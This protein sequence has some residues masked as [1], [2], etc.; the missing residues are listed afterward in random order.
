MK[1]HF[2]KCCLLFKQRFTKCCLSFRPHLFTCCRLFRPCLLS[3][4]L[5][6]RPH[7]SYYLGHI[8]LWTV[9]CLSNAFLIYFLLFM[10][11]SLIII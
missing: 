11:R 5:L 10:T 2:L 8:Y 3:C 7:F 1:Q 9:Y 4:C 6:F